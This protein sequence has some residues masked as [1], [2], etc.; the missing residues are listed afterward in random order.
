MDEVA[1]AFVK[2]HFAYLFY[3]FFTVYLCEKSECVGMPTDNPLHCHRECYSCCSVFCFEHISKSKK[4]VLALTCMVEYCGNLLCSKCTVSDEERSGS[5]GY[6]CFACEKHMCN[7]C[8][9]EYAFLVVKTMVLCCVAKNPFF[10]TGILTHAMF[11]TTLLVLKGMLL[12]F[13]TVTRPPPSI[14]TVSMCLTSVLS[15][16]TDLWGTMT[17]VV[18]KRL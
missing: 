4:S 10:V 11:L 14:K 8:F 9:F 16:E 5:I 13:V 7:Q 15:V 12:A 1:A 3:C 17:S 6:Y 18:R 2:Q